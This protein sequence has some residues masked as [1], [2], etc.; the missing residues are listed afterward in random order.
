MCPPV[1]R[2]KVTSRG[3]PDNRS[4]YGT[5]GRAG[6]FG[7]GGSGGRG[8]PGGAAGPASR[9]AA[10]DRARWRDRNAAGDGRCCIA[11]GQ[12]EAWRA[13]DPDRPASWPA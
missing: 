4:A 10:E 9:P 8:R 3:N 7:S 2:D 12:T 5:A 1:R 13:G 11:R 6:S